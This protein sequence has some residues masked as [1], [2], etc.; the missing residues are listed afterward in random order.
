MAPFSAFFTRPTFQHV[1]TL[2]AGVI[3]SPGRRTVTAALSIM[4]MREEANFTN[5]HRVLNRN[6]WLPRGLARRLL[7][8]LIAAFVPDGP[9]VIGIDET[10]ERR[11]VKASSLR[12]ISVMLLAPIPWAGRI[13]GPAAADGAGAVRASC[14]RARMPAQAAARRS[15]RDGSRSLP[16]CDEGGAA[17]RR[18]SFCLP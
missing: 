1:L 4:G 14:P 12:W 11:F 6:H 15:D 2:G 7:T 13:W 17:S 8:L 16:G 10:I 9:V 18:G 5:F 3:L